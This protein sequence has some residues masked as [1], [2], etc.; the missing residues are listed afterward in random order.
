MTGLRS[1][2]RYLVLLALA[3]SVSLVCAEASTTALAE[4]PGW[5]SDSSM[6]IYLSDR[7][8]SDTYSVI[9]LTTAQGLNE[10]QST[11]NRISL[12]GPLTIVNASNFENYA[13]SPIEIIYLSCSGD[14]SSTASPNTML[15]AMMAQKPLAILLYSTEANYCSL[16]YTGDLEFN[17]IFTVA[18]MPVSVD[19]LNS[20]TDSANSLQA[21]I[22]GINA[23]TNRTRDTGER[24]SGGSAIAMSLLYGITGIISLLF[25][26]I[27]S[28]GAVRAHRY[29]ERY[30]PRE[31]LGNQPGQS[32]ARGL[33]RAVLGT[34]PII[35]FGDPV[36]PKSERMN[37]V[38]SGHDIVSPAPVARRDSSTQAATVLLAPLSPVASES[39]IAKTKE[40]QSENEKQPNDTTT[41]NGQCNQSNESIKTNGDNNSNHNSN[42]D[43]NDHL[44]CSICTDDFQV[45][46]D[47]RVLPC[48]HKFHPACVDPWLLNVSGTC[49]LCRFDL[50]TNSHISPDDASETHTILPPPLDHSHDD[51]DD[52]EPLPGQSPSRPEPDHRRSPSHSHH[53]TSKFLDFHRLRMARTRDERIQIL[54]QLRNRTSSMP[55]ASSNRDLGQG[56]GHVTVSNEAG[57][58]NGEDQQCQRHSL[59]ERFRDRFKIR[60]RVH[61]Q[62]QAAPGS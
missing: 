48:D 47:V 42:D 1:L 14:T 13:A 20:I 8:Y 21:Q 43:D 18:S 58:S 2:C 29:P 17:R 39:Q 41:G 36:P 44:G 26:I 38:E 23:Q 51:D 4:A 15:N 24:R 56:S 60:T 55:H 59:A 54:R 37:D 16:S 9:P 50:N 7:G 30:G 27:V 5:A 49:P 52:D 32:R 31:S 22:S 40:P 35:K 11:R 33:A 10:S 45:G 28:T 12:S 34:L 6:Y 3:R 57:A 62:D 19:I 53:R 61:A 46:E 25:L